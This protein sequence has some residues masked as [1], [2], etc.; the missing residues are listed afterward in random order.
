MSAETAPGFDDWRRLL[1]DTVDVA[2]EIGCQPCVVE[3]L[4]GMVGDARPQDWRAN[5]PFWLHMGDSKQW[6]ALAKAAVA[7]V[8]PTELARLVREAFSA[9]LRFEQLRST[10]MDSLL[11]R[12]AYPT[13]SKL[14]ALACKAWAYV[15]WASSIVIVAAL[16]R[17]PALDDASAIT[18]LRTLQRALLHWASDFVSEPDLP[19]KEVLAWV[20]DHRFELRRPAADLVDRIVQTLA[21]V[22]AADAD[23]RKVVA[24]L[25]ASAQSLREQLAQPVEA[26]A[27]AV[28]PLEGS[29]PA[30]RF[31]RD[32]DALAKVEMTRL[33]FERVKGSVSR[34][35]R[36]RGERWVAV[37]FHPGKWGWSRWA[38]GSFCVAVALSAQADAEAVD[39]RDTLDF[40]GV[41]PDGEFAPLLALNAAAR[42]T[43]TPSGVSRSLTPCTG[44]CTNASCCRTPAA[45]TGACGATSSPT[46]SS[47]IRPGWPPGRPCC[48]RRS[49]PGSTR[50]WPPPTRRPLEE[51]P[52]ACPMLAG[53]ARARCPIHRRPRRGSG[54]CA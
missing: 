19:M 49:R 32:W 48:C 18:V 29:Y 20:A 30:S 47:T 3:V 21:L 6:D 22:P 16:R 9:Q 38:G 45:R 35:R 33:G 41:F 28:A 53:D 10:R 13:G 17:K 43:A 7:A 1:A 34:W 5:G 54:A 31:H 27:D 15:A 25:A 12:R 51:P 24:K 42:D 52:S 2:R 50:R 23:D 40:F 36:P 44:N 46:S 14:P 39:S 8:A 4:A 37:G 26:R 11:L